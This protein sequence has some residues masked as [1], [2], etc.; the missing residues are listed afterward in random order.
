VTQ[1]TLSSARLFVPFSAVSRGD[2]DAVLWYE[3]HI[4]KHHITHASIIQHV[5]ALTIIAFYVGSC[6]QAA[7]SRSGG[8]GGADK[9]A[10]APLRP[11]LE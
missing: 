10:Y 2:P 5:Q 9:S 11:M 7:T 4:P 8:S 1:H 6:A 3:P